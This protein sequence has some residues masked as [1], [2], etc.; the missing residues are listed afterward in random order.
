MS[1][2]VPRLLYTA[3]QSRA[4]DREA[5]EVH[6]LPGPLLMARAAR[7][8]FDFLLARR[9]DI[10]AAP[11]PFQILCGPGNNGGDGLLL[12]MLATARGIPTQVLLI[13]GKPR[14]ADAAAA[15]ARAASAGVPIADYVPGRLGATL[16]DGGVIVD[17]MLGTGISG[18]LRPPY[19]A[20]IDEIN[21]ASLPVLALDVPSGIDSDTGAVCGAAVNAT[22]TMSFITPKRGLHTGAGAAH[23][24]DCVCDDLEVP[25]AAYE[26]AGPAFEALNLEQERQNLPPLRTTAHKGHFGRCLII[27]GDH[28]MGGAIILAAEAALRSGAG[29]VRVATREAHIAGLLAGRPETMVTAVDHRNAL[30]PLLEWADA[31]V[32]GPGLGQE[33]WGEQ[34]LHAALGCNKPLLLDADALNLL[35]KQGPRSLPPGSVITPHPGEAAR[36]LAS[37]GT[38]DTSAVQH[39]RFAAAS[40]LL[41][42]WGATVVLKGNGSLVL[43]TGLRGLCLDGNPGMASGGM[44]DVLSGIVGAFLAQ[45]LPGSQAAAL[46]V[47]LHARAGDAAVK[48]ASP[49]SLLA[50]DLMPL[51]GTLLP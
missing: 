30:I 44:G 9:P 27:G 16:G 35:G 50:R 41:E 33:V 36:L 32:I 15:A 20:A 19:R 21:S 12:A 18:E 2:K 6:G 43:G 49:R 22:W 7:A 47:V 40:Q 4:V 11:Q 13:D 39:D 25:E 34:M 17:A 28:G 24:G 26:V 45:G 23:A 14:S 1:M 10:A 37:R 38:V 3:A 31:V 48:E 46:G 5:I 51:L 42:L 29:L 8:A